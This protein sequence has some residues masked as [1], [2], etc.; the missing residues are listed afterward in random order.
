MANE[1]WVDKEECISCGLCVDNLPEVFRY[2]DDG[3]AEAFNS[4]GASEDE[5][6]EEAIDQCPVGCIHWK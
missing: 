6:Q 3:K 5:I 4:T 2:D 1:V